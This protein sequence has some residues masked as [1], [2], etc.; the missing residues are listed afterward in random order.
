MDRMV[1]SLLEY[2]ANVVVY[3]LKNTDSGHLCPFHP[4]LVCKFDGA[5][6]PSKLNSETY[7]L[8]QYFPA[9]LRTPQEYRQSTCEST[10]VRRRVVC[11]R[12]QLVEL[13]GGCKEAWACEAEASFM[14]R[15]WGRGVLPGVMV[16]GLAPSA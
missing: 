4:R 7:D 10:P 14:A 12:V 5:D 6:L 13:D 9:W 15:V 3:P 8:L 2:G 1:T 11:W 16:L